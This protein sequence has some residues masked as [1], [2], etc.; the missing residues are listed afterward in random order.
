MTVLLLAL[1]ALALGAPLEAQTG[2]VLR[3]DACSVRVLAVDPQ[4]R[5]V[6][7]RTASGSRTPAIVFRGRAAGASEEDAP[8]VFD[9]FNPRGQ[10]YQVLLGSDYVNGQAPQG[11]A[12]TPGQPV[13]ATLAV[14]GSSIEWTSMYGVWR[15]VPRLEGQDKPCGRAQAF[16]IRP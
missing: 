1:V 11:G 6:P 9:V 5:V 2:V 3:A 8:L 13:Q 4:G 12:Q 7:A 16:T 10:R 15:V 14:A